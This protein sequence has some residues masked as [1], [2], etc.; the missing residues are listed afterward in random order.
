MAGHLSTVRPTDL[1]TP[2]ALGASMAGEVHNVRGGASL[3]EG[4]DLS[5]ATRAALPPADFTLSRAGYAVLLV[6]A[7]VARGW[8]EEDN[9]R[10]IPTVP[11]QR[12]APVE[13]PAAP[14]P[15][16]RPA[17]GEVVR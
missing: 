13:R 14:V 10:A 1:L 8:S 4:A 6:E 16:P 15:A 3:G 2:V 5:E 12:P 9:E 11:G 17:T 7:A